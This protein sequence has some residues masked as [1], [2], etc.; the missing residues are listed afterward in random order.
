[1][2]TP[3]PFDLPARMNDAGYCVMLPAQYY[4]SAA[5]HFLRHAHQGSLTSSRWPGKQGTARRRANRH[6]RVVHDRVR[7]AEL[8]RGRARAGMRRAGPH[9]LRHQERR[10]ARRRAAQR[11]AAQQP[12]GAHPAQAVVEAPRGCQ[13]SASQAL[14]FLRLLQQRSSRCRD[15]A[16]RSSTPCSCSAYHHTA[17]Q[18]ILEALCSAGPAAIGALHFSQLSSTASPPPA[19]PTQRS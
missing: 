3:T 19:L 7:L 13:A 1:M 14:I 8:Q 10:A 2:H 12:A 17:H 15:S 9:H 5:C 11:A 4:S 6:E 18:G 16:P